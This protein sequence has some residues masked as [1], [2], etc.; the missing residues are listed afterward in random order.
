MG[1]ANHTKYHLQ[2]TTVRHTRMY[3]FTRFLYFAYTCTTVRYTYFVTKTP[4]SCTKKPKSVTNLLTDL[5]RIYHT[6]TSIK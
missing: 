2:S 6:D 5:L 4:S 1:A 3:T